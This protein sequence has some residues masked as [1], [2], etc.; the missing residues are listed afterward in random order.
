M[1]QPTAENLFGTGANYNATTDKFEITKAALE[2]AGITNAATAAPIEIY[3]AIVKNAH[4]WLVS[5]TDEAVLA[6][7]S[8][9]V[10]APFFRN[11]VDKTSFTYQAQFFGAYN[12]PAFDPDDL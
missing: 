4:S 8:L 3:A 10:S 6:A 9:S 12:A 1:A 11:G 7:S 2:A 5:N